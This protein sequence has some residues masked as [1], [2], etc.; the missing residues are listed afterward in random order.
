MQARVSEGQESASSL[1]L[2]EAS[3]QILRAE[4]EVN[5]K[6]LWSYRLNYLKASGQLAVLWK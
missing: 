6:Q 5:K 3:L 1:N 2:D 4:Y